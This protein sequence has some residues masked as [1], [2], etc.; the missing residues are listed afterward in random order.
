M[1]LRSLMSSNEPA[2]SHGVDFLALYFILVVYS[3]NPVASLISCQRRSWAAVYFGVLVNLVLPI[4][5]K[6]GSLLSLARS[7][8]AG[9]AHT[10]WLQNMEVDGSPQNSHLLGF[11]GPSKAS[12]THFNSAQISQRHFVC[13]AS[14][15]PHFSHFIDLFMKKC[16]KVPNRPINYWVLRKPFPEAKHPIGPPRPFHIAR[17]A[18][19][20]L[21][22]P[23]GANSALY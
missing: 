14:F 5:P 11:I 18:Y 1:V 21:H 23:L 8:Q 22:I 6:S 2:L 17:R 12:L 20:A 7:L 15:P 4:L 10:L 16:V 3:L 13:V 19:V 9:L